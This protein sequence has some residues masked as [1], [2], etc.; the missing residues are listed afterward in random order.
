MP[1]GDATGSEENS[2]MNSP[3]SSTGRGRTFTQPLRARAMVIISVSAGLRSS[4][5]NSST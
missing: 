3:G 4:V 5:V 2:V 1:S